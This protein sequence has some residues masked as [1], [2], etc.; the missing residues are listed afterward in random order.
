MFSLCLIKRHFMETYGKNR[1]IVPLICIRHW[2]D[3]T[4]PLR[5][6]DLATWKSTYELPTERYSF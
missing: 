3:L 2:M 1:G 6:Y 5:T 4:G